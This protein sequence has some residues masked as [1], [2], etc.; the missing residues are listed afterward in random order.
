[1]HTGDGSQSGAILLIEVFLIWDMSEE[2]GEGITVVHDGVRGYIVIDDRDI[3]F[4][5]NFSQDF[6]G[7]FKISDFVFR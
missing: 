4:D 7:D 2:V 3:K 6:L 1:M 5:T